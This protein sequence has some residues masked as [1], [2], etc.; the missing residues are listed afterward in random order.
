[1]Y[2]KLIMKLFIHHIIRNKESECVFTS[3]VSLIRA[4]IKVYNCDWICK[5]VHSSHI[6]FFNF[7]NSKI[8][9]K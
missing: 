2:I 8:C 7:G 9:L 6:Q 4:V 3:T 1:M 5:N